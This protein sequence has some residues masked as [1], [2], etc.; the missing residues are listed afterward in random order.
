MEEKIVFNKNAKFVK[1]YD[2]TIDMLGENLK[3][4]EFSVA[5]KISRLICYSDCVI[6]NGGHQNGKV[7]SIKEI[8]EHL[9]MNYDA[10]RKTMTSLFKNEVFTYHNIKSQDKDSITIKSIICNPWI[11][12]RGDKISIEI[13]ELFENSKWRNLYDDKN[14]TDRDSY[15]YLKWRN[16]VLVRDNNTCQC[17]G[18]TDEL[19]V[20]HIEPYSTNKQLRVDINNGMVLCRNCHSPVVKGSFHNTYGTRNNNA[21]QLTEYIKLKQL[22]VG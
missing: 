19:E 13:L 7:L 1:L 14:N 10:L 12:C 5:I 22:E 4:G 15:E 18:S 3:Y 6:R 17:C 21:D 20:H 8:S 9:N 16:S 11:F 2:D